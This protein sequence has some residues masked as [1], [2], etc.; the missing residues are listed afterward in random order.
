MAFIGL[1]WLGWNFYV[2]RTTVV[3]ATGGIYTEGIVGSL[4][5]INPVLAD[6]SEAD[7]ALEAIIFSGLFR[8]DGR[9][10]VEK[11]LAEL[12]ELS[13]DK[14]E[15]LVTL[16]PNI[17]WHDGEPLTADDVLFTIDLIKN[18]A[19]RNPYAL[20]WQGVN[21]EKIS[22]RTIKITIPVP[23]APFI[24]NL[25]FRILPKHLWQDVPPQNFALSEL[26]LKPIGSGPYRF[27]NFT[28][29]KT[30]AVTSYT[31][32]ANRRYH[33]PGPYIDT[34]VLRFY[35]N[36]EDALVALKKKEIDGLAGIPPEDASALVDSGNLRIMT[37]LLPRYFAVFWNTEVPPFDDKKMRL[38][39]AMAVNRPRLINEVLKGEGKIMNGP[40]EAEF[41]SDAATSTLEYNPASSS[42][43][44][45][46]LGWKI[47]ADG[48]REKPQPGGGRKPKPPIKLEFELFLPDTPLLQDVASHLI[49]DWQA[50]GVRVTAKSLTVNELLTTLQARSYRAILYGQLLTQDPDPFSFWHSSQKQAPGLNLSLW[51]NKAA[52]DILEK[53]RETDDA[54]QKKE[55]LAQFQ[56]LVIQEQPAAFLYEPNYIV[57]AAAA[58]HFPE[59]KIFSFPF[60]RF[61]T[62][63]EWYLYTKR[64]WRRS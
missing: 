42:Q 62:I 55:L 25:T 34:V 56:N 58:F 17:F 54:G 29:D 10:E 60:E 28:R 19:L 59:M 36:Y 14:R 33:L 31:L 53:V 52:D 21:A 41:I 27:K 51:S 44:L 22:D 9:G 26:N 64:I 48:V 49:Q 6:T 32:T 30:G 13:E 46:D 43:V 63:N 35:P 4:R 47:G 24:Q 45:D 15:Y 18:P 11:D 1:I 38:A 50:V 61:Q 12:A 20:N 5:L 37:P 23:Y 57:A 16:K 8:V 39:L 2:S 40:V 3:P 7:G